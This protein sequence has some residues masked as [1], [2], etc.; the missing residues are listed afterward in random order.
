MS[1]IEIAFS[2]KFLFAII[3]HGV[4]I[5]SGI[6]IFEYLGNRYSNP[7]LDFSW[8]RIG[9]PFYRA[10]VIAIFV[11]ST[12]PIIFGLSEAPGLS[13]LI[14]SGE[15]RINSVINILFLISLFFPLIPIIGRKIELILPLQAIACCIMVFS[16]LAEHYDL[17]T[18]TDWP[19]FNIFVIIVLLAILT[20]FIAN[21]M[22][23]ELGSKLDKRFH[24]AGCQELIGPAIILFMQAP[25]I[26]LYSAA[27]GRQLV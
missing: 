25:A 7:V 3:V 15:N 10:F 4:L 14:N 19:G 16:W 17:Q 1:L 12:Y 24:V 5:V 18:Y 8:E 11:F 2:G 22:A 21:L 20:H 9:M 6:F 26:L 27:L 13:E 23:N